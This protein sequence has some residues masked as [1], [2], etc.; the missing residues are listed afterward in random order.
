MAPT[1]SLACH[2]PFEKTPPRRNNNNSINETAAAA[3]TTR[4]TPQQQSAT[5]SFRYLYDTCIDNYRYRHQTQ[6]QSAISSSRYMHIDLCI[7]IIKSQL[8][9]IIVIATKTHTCIV[10]FSLHMYFNLCS[11]NL[12]IC[13]NFLCFI[14]QVL[15]QLNKSKSKQ[16]KTENRNK[17]RMKT[18]N[19]KVEKIMNKKKQKQKQKNNMKIKIFAKLLYERL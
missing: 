2:A 14:A 13:S 6:Q 3:T 11:G 7:S 16:T 17:N 4:T 10:L 15:L 19:M 8:S 12:W 18:N 5:S 1:Q 9:I